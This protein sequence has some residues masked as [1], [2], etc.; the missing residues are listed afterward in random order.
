MEQ[1]IAMTKANREKKEATD[2][3]ANQEDMEPESEY[4]EVPM[5]DGVVKPV[6]RRKKRHR[7][8]HLAAGRRG[9]TKEL[10]R[11]NC[12]RKNG[13]YISLRNYDFMQIIL[14]LDLEYV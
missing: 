10:T 8:R 1:M 4:R 5:E 11:G 14:C 7:G 9:E 2:L 6:G 3:K 13:H 12:G